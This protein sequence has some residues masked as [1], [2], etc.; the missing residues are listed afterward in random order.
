MSW[1]KFAESLIPGVSTYGGL[2]FRDG[3]RV[4]FGD[5]DD[6]AIYWDEPLAALVV[7]GAIHP[8]GDLLLFDNQTL[9]FGTDADMAMVWS[10]AY[11]AVRVFGGPLWFS[12]NDK[13]LTFGPAQEGSV[14]R[15]VATGTTGSVPALEL[16]SSEAIWLRGNKVAVNKSITAG[17]N[18]T[19][20]DVLAFDPSPERLVLC[21]ANHA[22]QQRRVPAGIAL[23]TETS[24]S[25][26]PL[27]AALQGMAVAVNSDLTGVP[28]GSAVFLSAATPGGVSAAV[29]NVAGSELWRIGFVVQAGAAGAN[30]VKIDICRVDQ[31]TVPAPAAGSAIPLLRLERQSIPIDIGA[32]VETNTL[33]DPYFAGQCVVLYSNSTLGGSRAVTVPTSLQTGPP[34][35]TMTLTPAGDYIELVAITIAGVPVW[36][37]S[38][39]DGVVLS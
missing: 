26:A 17:E 30:L 15:T 19:A 6:A 28:L 35:T 24:G 32:G 29:T 1:T 34:R 5:D 3:Q 9:A 14:R 21:D 20:G 13:G 10:D 18:F 16:N 4:S 8:T 27:L 2:Y 22:T 11:A 39:N 31:F 33:A 25:G 36:R 23:S 38:G 37:V 12:T 7:E